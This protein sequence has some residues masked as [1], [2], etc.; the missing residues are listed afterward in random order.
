MD[1]D[2]QRGFR[3]VA[4][5]SGIPQLNSKDERNL[6][7][8]M[9]EVPTMKISRSK[10]S[11][12]IPGLNY[13]L[14]SSAESESEELNNTSKVSD[15][16]LDGSYRRRSHS[17]ASISPKVLNS[18]KTESLFNGTL[19]LTASPTHGYRNATV[20]RRSQK[21]LTSPDSFETLDSERFRVSDAY[22]IQAISPL[23]EE[24]K[25]ARHEAIDDVADNF[26]DPQR[27]MEPEYD[28]GDIK[29]DKSESAPPLIESAVSGSS[30]LQPLRGFKVRKTNSIFKEHSATGPNTAIDTP[31]AKPPSFLESTSSESIPDN[32]PLKSEPK[33]L[34]KGKIHIIILTILLLLAA[35][36]YIPTVLLLSRGSKN[37]VFRY[38]DSLSPDS[39]SDLLDSLESQFHVLRNGTHL[40]GIE[41]Y[42]QKN[43]SVNHQLFK[44]I[45]YSPLDS[46]E[47]QCGATP[48]TVEDD[49]K[50]LSRV[51]KR[52]RNYG[53][54]CNQSNYI[55]DAIKNLNLDM[56]LTMGVWIG[57]NDTVNDQQLDLA[58]KVLTKYP[59]KS[60]HSV[61]IG[62]EVLFREDK[63]E[64]E[65]IRIIKEMRKFVK[66]IGYIDLPV[67]TSEIGSLITE[68]LLKGCDVIGANIHPFFGGV[69]VSMATN[70][71]Y[72]F[73]KY[74]IEPLNEGI[75]T[76]IMITEVGWPYAGGRY[77]GSV[78]N[79][80]NFQH[81]LNSWI[82]ESKSNDY[83]WY[84]FEAFD[85]PWKRI[86]YEDTNTW[87]TEWG[88][89]DSQRQMKQN[90]TFPTC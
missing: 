6:K 58:K 14:N 5:T 2:R 72:E 52:V 26:S 89:F 9:V 74:Q 3:R 20:I 25:S 83:D 61:L 84:Y 88:L 49:M 30:I 51:T 1:S 16:G 21:D 87:E 62:N 41:N 80:S 63:S 44:A 75:N 32:I 15:F 57:S 82:C 28:L 8:A 4:T 36:G 27:A 46:M 31:E 85:E 40:E 12:F 55:L 76:K 77:K 60:F 19:L 73:L 66:Q 18:A 29:L 59:R 17:I 71:T 13:R 65:L 10:S 39:R 35:C 79:S 90:I 78:A 56:S 34:K 45:S 70:W 64:K 69:D 22:R 11:S 68:D 50:V 67:G 81:F 54:Q 38:F 7:P 33:I 37:G 53:M 86:F 23:S 24:A 43:L 48:Q 42:N 47:P